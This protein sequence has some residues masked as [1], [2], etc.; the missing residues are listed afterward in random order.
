MGGGT[1]P[2]FLQLRSSPA[3]QPDPHQGGVRVYADEDGQLRTIKSNGAGAAVA[4][5]FSSTVV[6]TAADLEGLSDTPL[7]VIPSPG[8]GKVNAVMGLAGWMNA[9]GLI[10]GG[11]KIWLLNDPA[12]YDLVSPFYFDGSQFDFGGA[13]VQY[14]PAK[15]DETLVG[16]ALGSST[17]GFPTYIGSSTAITAAEGSTLTVTA[18]Y[19]IID[20]LG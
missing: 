3:P 18:L 14:L 15:V 13:G 10:S 7:I 8:P 5:V 17:E 20:E 9:T 19:T 6:L 11:G 1:Y 16:I 4:T 2:D 12:E